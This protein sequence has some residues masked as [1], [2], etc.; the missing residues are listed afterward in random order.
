MRATTD[1]EG[2][3]R[4][5]PEAKPGISNLMN[6]YSAFS[7]ESLED[8]QTSYSGKGYGDFKKDLVGI[9]QE[10]NGSHKEKLQ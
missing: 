1:S 2:E 4:F 6:I 5:D 10:G 3:I 7:G 9:V 8:I